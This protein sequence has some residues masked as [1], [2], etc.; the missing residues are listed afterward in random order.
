[1]EAR[2][3]EELRRLRFADP[4]LERAFRADYAERVRGQVRTVLWLVAVIPVL[5]VVA[6]LG[7]HPGA[8]HQL[9]F[10]LLFV[11]PLALVLTVL[12]LPYSRLFTRLWEPAIAVVCLVIGGFSLLRLLPRPEGA[13]PV[14][15]L[16]LIVY[17]LVRLRFLTAVLVYWTLLAAFLALSFWALRPPPESLLLRIPSVVIA[18]FIG[19]LAAFTAEQSAR[20]DFLLRHLLEAERRKS[21]RLLLNILPAVIAERLKASAPPGEA[22]IA[23]LFTEVTVLFADLVDFTPLAAR[24]SPE[25]VVD[26]L[27]QVFSRFDRLVEQ[28]GLEKIKTIGDAYMAVAGLPAPRPDHAQAAAALALAMQEEVARLAAPDGTPLR[29]RIGLHTGPVIAG[30]IGQ[31]KFSYDL[32]GD[33]VNLASRME[34][35]GVPGAIQVTAATRHRLG[36]AYRFEPRGGVEVKGKGTVE[37]FLLWA[38]LGA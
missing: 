38:R 18:N 24:L 29:L 12:A 9:R 4:A 22:R 21:D 20:R 30:V 16:A 19:M 3:E 23:D 34:S 7:L 33:T 25:Q 6:E 14:V 11:L 26:L 27:N 10:W 1:M 2:H 35:H 32:W 15:V 5:E 36:E 13:A 31:K 17:T 37:A 8:I 28:H